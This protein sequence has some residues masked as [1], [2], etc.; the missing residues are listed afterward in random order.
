MANSDSITIDGLKVFQR[1]LK[2]FDAQIPKNVKA[3]MKAAMDVVVE[4]A[5]PRV[6]KRS[7]KAR[8]SIKTFATETRAGV[9]AG[10]SRAPYYPWLEFGGRIFTGRNIIK[11]KWVKGGRYLW[12][13]LARKHDE[14]QLLMERALHQ[15]ARDAGWMPV[16]IVRRSSS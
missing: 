6:P 13:S 15:A 10:G 5:R 4:D 14:V 16:T 7:G 3:A 12:V 2:Q 8:A 11:R 9:R 1:Q